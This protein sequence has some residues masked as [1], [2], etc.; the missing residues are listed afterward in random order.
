MENKVVSWWEG[1]SLSYPCIYAGNTG[2]IVYIGDVVYS[3]REICTK[4]AQL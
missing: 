3:A 1:M 4:D 2:N